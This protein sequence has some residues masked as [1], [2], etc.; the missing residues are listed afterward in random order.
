MH[1][2]HCEIQS[3]VVIQLIL[4][5]SWMFLP[6]NSE[7]FRH[8]FSS[9]F[10]H[11][12]VKS[13]AASK[14]RSSNFSS[15]FFGGIEERIAS[16]D[17]SV[18]S[19]HICHVVRGYSGHLHQHPG[20]AMSLQSHALRSGG[21]VDVIFV[22]TDAKFDNREYH[23]YKQLIDGINDFFKGFDGSVSAR[24]HLVSETVRRNRHVVHSLSDMED[25]GYRQFAA[26]D[27]VLDTISRIAH[28]FNS[29]RF[30]EFIYLS[31]SDNIIR[32]PLH[33][34]LSTALR[35]HPQESLYFFKT[36]FR[37]KFVSG[38]EAWIGNWV[39][40]RSLFEKLSFIGAFRNYCN[41][42][43]T[44]CE[45]YMAD[46]S[47]LYSILPAR[48]S[49]VACSEIDMC[50]FTL[51]EYEIFDGRDMREQWYAALN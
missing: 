22:S 21:L 18:Q 24:I 45:A 51:H 5:K 2:G 32:Q 34:S 46:G 23:V 7:N 25:S 13:V 4:R 48:Y 20:T 11:S 12:D 40:R 35:T 33:Q 28:A 37:W 30:C 9:L 50:H 14:L 29:T 8:D 27:Y 3:D 47:L 38:I 26:T 41:H 36:A 1:T 43:R 19:P 16:L 6:S 15:S 44:R 17:D 10:L 39:A 49:P 31:N 42:T